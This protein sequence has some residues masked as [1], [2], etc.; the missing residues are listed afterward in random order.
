MARGALER[1]ARR[2]RMSTDIEQAS[3]PELQ[4]MYNLHKFDY[5]P[6][7]LVL[8]PDDPEDSMPQKEPLIR[9]T[10]S[11]DAGDYAELGTLS[12]KTE[13]SRSWLIRQAIRDL[14]ER[15]RDQD[16]P[17]LPLWLARRKGG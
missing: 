14:L 8:V 6:A 9:V 10:V 12:E 16:Q 7:E 1:D 2:N 11:L 3:K 4:V 17:E 15:C 13:I 5:D